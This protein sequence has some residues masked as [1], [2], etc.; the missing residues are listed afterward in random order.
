MQADP[1]ETIEAR[2]A[3]SV[4]CVDLAGRRYDIHIGSGLLPSGGA[5]LQQ[6]GLKRAA[7]VADAAV[8]GLAER[9]AGDL[10][11]AGLLLGPV[12]P[13]ASGEASKSFDGLER[14]C[15][16]LLDR[17]LE[18]HHGVVAVG[19]GVI[20]DLAGFAAAI[21]K[22]GARLVQVPTTLLAQ[23]DSSVGGKTGI[24]TRH[25]KNL[26][27][28]FHQPALV[29]ADI[30]TLKTLPAREL[31]AGYAE[32]VKYGLLGD[33]AFFAWLERNRGAVLALDTPALVRAITVSCEMKAGIVARDER[34]SGE[35][36][37]LNLGH[38]FGHAIEAWA[39]YSGR[40]LHGEAVAIGMVLAAEFSHRLDLVPPS[41]AERIAAHLRAAGLPASLA[42]LRA[43]AEGELPSPDRL[44]SYMAQDKK[45]ADGQI[46]LVLLRAIGEAFVMPNV[47]AGNI[48]TF[49]TRK[50][51]EAAEGR[52]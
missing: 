15:A 43:M 5:H 50:L 31:R 45:V 27:G 34:E 41:A 2:T 25:G 13:V 52:A 10:E 14:V 9:L 32:V 48:H 26:I 46:N 3:A 47:P 28:A 29:L 11:R 21:V 40:V 4:V 33:A 18:R 8:M 30:D 19:G 36:A 22:R 39:G 44:L 51:S 37:L 7:I 12:I 17:G 23:V 24:N 6:L 38:T 20:G 1:P 16:A 42:D 35:R 49:L